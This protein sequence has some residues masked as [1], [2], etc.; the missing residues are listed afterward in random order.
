MSTPPSG[1]H[2]R[3]ATAN[4]EPP[5][6]HDEHQNAG[7]TAL[8]GTT[9]DFDA[10]EWEY[11]RMKWR[12]RW[13]RGWIF[14]TGAIVLSA[15]VGAVST[16]WLSGPAAAAVGSALAVAVFGVVSA[17]GKTLLDMHAEQKAALPGQL[18]TASE[19]GRPRRVR[20][21]ND[22]IALRVHPAETFHRTV[23]GQSVADR[24]PSYVR[25]D[26]QEQLGAAVARG[27]FVL[28]AGDSTAGKTRMAYEAIRA[29]CPDHVLMAPASRESLAMIVP[30]VL[31]QRR[32]VVWLDDLERFLG[33]GG[34]TASVAGRLLGDG[35]RQV[36]LLA[37]LRSAEFDRYSAREESRVT[38]IERDSWLE[39]R[40]VLD[41]AAV[42][43]LQRRWS[44]EELKRA[45]DYA[46]DPRISTALGKTS[47]FGL[48]EILA[49]GPHLAGD[50]RNAWR[51]GAHPRGAALVAAAVDCRRAG[52][53]DPQPIEVLAGLA[54]YY[55]NQQGGALLRPALLPM[56]W[57]GLLPPVMAPAACFYP[58][59]QM[60][61]IWPSITSSTSP[62]W[63]ASPRPSGTPLSTGPR[64]SRHSP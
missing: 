28:L 44:A 4:G 17:R 46:D 36:L 19:S 8:G 53:H 38:G 34:L 51:P 49:A 56:P 20:D 13:L 54:E 11:G 2:P 52:V 24:V 43:E 60:G 48:A 42:V 14:F 31:E 50:W 30:V 10:P 64:P 1:N 40:D 41:L 27:G 16:M 5:T 25:R 15:G 26:A 57:T 33:S 35:D 62:A 39:A 55:L 47:Q 63:T 45:R 29:L 7:T 21:L 9:P 6:E 18:V 12:S 3:L 59:A 37:T 32:C 22:P 23:N 61:T 58:P